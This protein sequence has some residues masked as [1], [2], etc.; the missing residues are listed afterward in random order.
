MVSSFLAAISDSDIAASW[1]RVDRSP[2]TLTVLLLIIFN[3]FRD[4]LKK[5]QINIKLAVYS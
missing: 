4:I 2:Y 5:Q 3:F 1:E